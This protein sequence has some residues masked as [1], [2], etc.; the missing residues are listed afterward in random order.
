MTKEFLLTRREFLQGVGAS[1]A[2]RVL[3]D[4]AAN[5]LLYPPEHRLLRASLEA[6]QASSRFIERNPHLVDLLH[7]KVK[8]PQLQESPIIQLRFLPPIL[9]NRLL[10]SMNDHLIKKISESSEISMQE[11][12]YD[13]EEVIKK[14]LGF[15]PREYGLKGLA[16]SSIMRR[17][18]HC[19]I[20]PSFP[21][22]HE[23]NSVI[24]SID[25]VYPIPV[26]IY[27]EESREEII[28]R[29]VGDHISIGIGKTI[30]SRKLTRQESIN[31]MASI[32]THEL[33]HALDILSNL[34]LRSHMSET[35]YSD[36]LRMRLEAI[37]LVGIADSPYYPSHSYHT[38]PESKFDRH[39]LTITARALYGDISEMTPDEI[40]AQ[41]MN[42]P[43]EVL[44][45]RLLRQPYSDD[46]K[47]LEYRTFG[48]ISGRDTEP[49]TPEEEM[50]L[51]INLS[52][53][54]GEHMAE[55][56]GIYMYLMTGFEDDQSELTN[57]LREHRIIQYLERVV[58]LVRP[59]DFNMIKK[60]ILQRS[61][62]EPY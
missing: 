5:M 47:R 60:Q 38:R 23:N 39:Q 28:G 46:L 51:A 12:Y 32:T 53:M 25:H 49:L 2:S 26:P 22:Q 24:Q 36:L 20:Q 54:H 34:S 42:Y 57:Q 45:E 11:I 17:W 52:T 18:N 8:H 21:V 50:R 40:L 14:E 15:D 1:A 7:D 55:L 10:R 62:L 19:L 41:S 9:E 44:E 29:F 13:W 3:P 35:D 33:V 56:G 30:F 37:D 58:A 59:S 48:I 43:R 4:S 31:I 27:K 6:E 61:G 16:P